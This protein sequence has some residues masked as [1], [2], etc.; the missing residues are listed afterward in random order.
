[1]SDQHAQRPA[2][3]FAIESL[4]WETAR[5]TSAARRSTSSTDGRPARVRGAV[6]SAD[7]RVVVEVDGRRRARGD[8][9]V[10]LG[11]RRSHQPGDRQ[12]LDDVASRSDLRPRT[13]RRP[14]SW[15]GRPL[16]PDASRITMTAPA[17][18]RGAQEGSGGFFSTGHTGPA[19]ALPTIP[20]ATGVVVARVEAA[21][22][23]EGDPE[24]PGAPLQATTASAIAATARRRGRMG[25]MALRRRAHPRCSGESVR[26][27]GRADSSIRSLGR[28]GVRGSRDRRSRGRSS[29]GE[30]PRP[31]RSP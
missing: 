1:M 15:S 7:P 30:A 22:V 21:G 14:R 8:R 12:R 28:P 31:S 6:T 26:R 18:G 20:A 29:R 5:A 27:P 19:V 16:P 17:T 3:E 10:R 23:G 24:P 13:S 4:R 25:V 2:S 11:R 9:D